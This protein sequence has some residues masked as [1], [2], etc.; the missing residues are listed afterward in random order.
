MIVHN[1][2]HKNKKMQGT[3]LTDIEHSITFKIKCEH[4]EIQDANFFNS[5]NSLFLTFLNT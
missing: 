1:I 3:I 5:I 4:P 2:V